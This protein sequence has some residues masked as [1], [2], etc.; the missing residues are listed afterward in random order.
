MRWRWCRKARNG[1]DL[2]ERGFLGKAVE[3]WRVKNIAAHREAF[4]FAYDVSEYCERMK[5]H[6]KVPGDCRCATIVTSL[7]LKMLADYQGALLLL[8]RGMIPQGES[9]FRCELEAFFLIAEMVND[10]DFLARWYRSDDR[11]RRRMIDVAVRTSEGGSPP[12]VNI[13]ELAAVKAEIETKA[14]GVKRLPGATDLVQDDQYT[15]MHGLYMDWSF[16]VHSSPR[17]VGEYLRQDTDGA[18]IR[19]NSP[20]DKNIDL[21]LA[22]GGTIMVEV[23]KPLAH[24]FGLD[25]REDVGAFETRF[26]HLMERVKRA[27]RR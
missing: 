15:W 9:L 1:M 14:K 25:V 18:G 23:W 19:G 21:T 26:Q 22:W 20:S 17:S 13:E 8:E 6:L 5:F 16:H 2:N 4:T 27:K 3:E 7:F 11:D 24:L 10:I 12:N